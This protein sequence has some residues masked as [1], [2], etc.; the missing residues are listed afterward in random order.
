[1]TIHSAV[2]LLKNQVS[3][4]EYNKR[5]AE[6][7]APPK[8]IKAKLRAAGDRVQ[9]LVVRSPADEPAP[10]D[11]S[12]LSQAAELRQVRICPPEMQVSMDLEPDCE[13]HM[14][15]RRTGEP[16]DPMPP[17]RRA[18]GAIQPYQRAP[19]KESSDDS[20][21]DAITIIGNPCGGEKSSTA[22]I[23]A[24]CCAASAAACWAVLECIGGGD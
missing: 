17:G 11:S 1:V 13:M 2:N 3:V 4:L 19:K 8:G 23:R 9:R 6:A 14:F 16:D 7:A 20:M 5:M 18:P 15:A 24:A 22:T 10:P 21:C 12:S